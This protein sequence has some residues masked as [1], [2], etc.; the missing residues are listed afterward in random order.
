VPTRPALVSQGTKKNTVVLTVKLSRVELRSF[1]SAGISHAAEK[2]RAAGSKLPRFYRQR[3][4]R[5]PLESS[6]QDS[7]VYVRARKADLRGRRNSG[8]GRRGRG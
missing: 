2:L 3:T 5:E 4:S 1:A 7:R 6:H 8:T